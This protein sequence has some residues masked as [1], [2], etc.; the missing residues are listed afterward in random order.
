MN[1]S[2]NQR[3][4]KCVPSLTTLRYRM[5]HCNQAALHIYAAVIIDVVPVDCWVITVVPLRISRAKVLRYHLSYDPISR[6]YLDRIKDSKLCG[7]QRRRG[8]EL[9]V[10]RMLTT[11]GGGKR[12]EQA[13]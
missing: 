12:H 1:V 3:L 13:P 8:L 2:D 6:L 7:A 4:K 11:G 9:L 10:R 5:K